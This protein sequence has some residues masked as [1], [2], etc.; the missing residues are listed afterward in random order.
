MKRL[1]QLNLLLLLISSVA[2]WEL[3]AQEKTLRV[4]D[5][6]DLSAQFTNNLIRFGMRCCFLESFSF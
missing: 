4:Y 5:W 6:K 3:P 1:I 2:V